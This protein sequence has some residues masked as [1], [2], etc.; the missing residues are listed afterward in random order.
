MQ[1]YLCAV[2][3]LLLTTGCK[4]T[5]CKTLPEP[6]DPKMEYTELKDRT[7]GFNSSYSIDLDKDGESDFSFS[8]LLVGDPILKR[9]YR[10]YYISSKFYTNCQVNENEE[11]PVLQRGDKIA[12][13]PL[14]GFHWYN[15]SHV[16]IAQKIIEM[17]GTSWSGNWKQ[18]AHAYQP[19][20][21]LKGD[22]T[23]YGWIEL[24]FDIQNERIILHRAA[25]A[26]EAGVEVKAGI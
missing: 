3:A 15:A 8:T 13:A 17:N 20:S 4:K 21:I 26:K 1:W 24:S 6:T 10:Q 7:V 2:T 11:T 18:V 19:V 12:S 25:V 14:E 5:T 16:V 22:K 23:Y 9:D